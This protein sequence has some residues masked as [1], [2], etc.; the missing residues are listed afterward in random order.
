MPSC[1]N[2]YVLIKL[3]GCSLIRRKVYLTEDKKK[4]IKHN[5]AI[6]MLADVKG[7]Y[8]YADSVRTN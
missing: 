3:E 8:R 6:I 1:N 7:R 2:S 5:G 4:Y